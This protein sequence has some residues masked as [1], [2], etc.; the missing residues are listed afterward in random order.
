[1]NWEMGRLEK[2]YVAI[3]DGFTSEFGLEYSLRTTER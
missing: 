2:P 1:M 3:I